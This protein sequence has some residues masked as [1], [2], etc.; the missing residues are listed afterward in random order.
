MLRVFAYF[1]SVL[2]LSF[3]IFY[4]VRPSH[5]DANKDTKLK[6]FANW[7]K[8]NTVFKKED[9]K[10]QICQWT[11]APITGFFLVPPQFKVVYLING[12]F[13]R[14]SFSKWSKFFETKYWN[15]TDI[16]FAKKANK[17]K[18]SLQLNKFLLINLNRTWENF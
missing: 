17:H 16:F 9:K 18:H 10:N 11:L 3:V 4:L 1:H 15:N 13:Y 12:K 6:L 8:K 14:N 2:I 5:C 7:A